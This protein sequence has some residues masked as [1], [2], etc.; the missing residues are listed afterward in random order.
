MQF[1]AE[2]FGDRFKQRSGLV[3]CF[4][5]GWA[6]NVKSRTAIQYLKWAGKMLR[7]LKRG[8]RTAPHVISYAKL[9]LSFH[10]AGCT[11][12]SGFTHASNC[13]DE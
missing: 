9:H 7:W 5:A 12:A 4:N 10:F 3:S 13:D 8:A 1:V 6:K 11:V 2:A